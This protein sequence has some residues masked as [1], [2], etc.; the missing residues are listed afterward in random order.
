MENISE[1]FNQLLP[2]LGAIVLLVLAVVFYQVIRLLAELV[3]TVKKVN[4]TVN[5]VNNKLVALDAP[6]QT[7][8][9]IS[10]SVDS[11]FKAGGH[12]VSNVVGKT[13]G[14]VQGIRSAVQ[15]ILKK[16]KE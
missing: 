7:V 6:V 16:E 9:N 2:I 5:D 14:T 10:T 15:S 13:K 1:F 12:A 11:G 8:K 3:I 4:I